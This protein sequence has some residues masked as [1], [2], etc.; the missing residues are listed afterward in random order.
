MNY[1]KED[2]TYEKKINSTTFEIECG[3]G[4]YVRS[5]SR[6]ICKKLNVDGHVVKLE[7]IESEPFKIENSVTIENFLYLYKKNDWKNLFLPIYSVLNKIKYA[8]N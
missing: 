2:F 4:F 7:R 8:E 6:D 5:L 3:K 1:V